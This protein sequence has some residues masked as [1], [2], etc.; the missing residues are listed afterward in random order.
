MMLFLLIAIRICA[1][2]VVPPN[3]PIAYDDTDVEMF[4]N[5]TNEELFDIVQ[6]IS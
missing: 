3:I 4:S 1:A 2:M 5:I 6:S